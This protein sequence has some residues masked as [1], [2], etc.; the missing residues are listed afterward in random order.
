ML[1]PQVILT[2]AYL[3]RAHEALLARLFPGAATV[4]QSSAGGAPGALTPTLRQSFHYFSG[5]DAA[6]KAKLRSILLRAGRDD[7]ALQ[8]DG[9]G[10]TVVFCASADAVA[11]VHAFLLRSASISAARR[12]D[13][14]D[15]DGA[16]LDDDAMRRLLRAP[17]MLHAGLGDD[18][19]VAA[20]AALRAGES[21]CL[22]ATDAAA[23]GLDALVEMTV[24]R[25]C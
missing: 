17:V 18:A 22:V 7:A 9:R 16:A 4:R 23:R 1:H 5:D 24:T 3:S 25:R 12:E 10:A 11:D 6:K 20:L 13:D 2:T 14:D 8:A 21:R 19:R 15:D